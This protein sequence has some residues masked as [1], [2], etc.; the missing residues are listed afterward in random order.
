MFSSKFQYL[1]K[2]K[3][4]PSFFVYRMLRNIRGCKS[5]LCTHMSW[6]YRRY[7]T[8][9]GRLSMLFALWDLLEA[10]FGDSCSSRPALI[11]VIPPR[12]SPSF[13]RCVYKFVNCLN[14]KTTIGTRIELLRFN[15]HN[16][17]IIKSSTSQA[18]ENNSDND[19]N[20]KETIIQPEIINEE[21]SSL[22]RMD[23]PQSN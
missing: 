16:S 23:W 8:N 4:F 6:R 19:N 12:N 15:F 17:S 21:N 1:H 3:S 10:S 5:W 9:A 11:T 13:N 7:P 18:C 22:W 20:N 2:D 14:N